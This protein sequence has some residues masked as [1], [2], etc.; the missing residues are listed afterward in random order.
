MKVGPTTNRPVKV[1]AANQPVTSIIDER[2]N[3]APTTSVGVKQTPENVTPEKV[4]ENQG[5]QEFSLGNPNGYVY[6]EVEL[7]SINIGA[8]AKKIALMTQNNLTFYGEITEDPELKK[9]CVLEG[10]VWRVYG[11]KKTV[12]AQLNFWLEE[13]MSSGLTQCIQFVCNVGTYKF[14]AFIDVLTNGEGVSKMKS[15]ITPI[16]YELTVDIC[17]AVAMFNPDMKEYPLQSSFV[18]DNRRLVFEIMGKEF[19]IKADEKVVNDLVVTSIIHKY[20]WALL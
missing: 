16:C 15:Y 20:I 3:E 4:V 13:Y 12:A 14:P 7:D 19:E 18:L 6:L 2:A 9:Q 8:Q 1:K 5:P 10:D 11:S 17:N